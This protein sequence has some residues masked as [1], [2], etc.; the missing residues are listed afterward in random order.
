MNEYSPYLRNLLKKASYLS[1]AVSVILIVCKSIAWNITGSVSMRATMMDSVLD[2]F[3][4]FV[5]WIAIQHALKPSDREHRFGHGK[6][7]ALAGIA[8]SV[9][10]CISALLILKEAFE[11][12]MHPKPIEG[13]GV[14]IGVMIFSIF[15]T[16]I[17]VAYQNF[18]IKKTQSL[19]IAG[20][21]LHYKSD[22][23]INASVMCSFMFAGGSNAGM[24][25]ALIASG[26]AMYILVTA[27]KILKASI[28][29]LMDKEMDDSVRNLISKIALDHPQILHINSLK[30]RKSGPF[31]FIQMDAYMDENLTLKEA[32]DIAHSV[33][34]NI[35]NIFPEASITIHQEA[36]KH[37]HIPP[38]HLKNL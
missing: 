26:I 21:S 24:V 2:A 8:Q 32:H 33:E 11:H 31:I 7:E 1:I 37:E 9:F 35:L 10:I 14:G 38:L 6:I 34:E 20:D 3:A 17:L 5:N 16:L 4:S 28:D 19:A 22:I 36:T 18:V 13:F 15:L 27:Y 29:V 12:F 23:L 30:T 25:D